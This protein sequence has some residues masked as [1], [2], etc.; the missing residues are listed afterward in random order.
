MVYAPGRH[1]PNPF[2]TLLQTSNPAQFYATYPFWVDPTTDDR[3][4][5][6]YT[7]KP[8][9]VLTTLSQSFFRTRTPDVTNIGLFLLVN[10][11][12]ITIGLTLAAIYLPLWVLSRRQS[13]ERWGTPIGYFF[14]LGLGFMFLEIALL[15]RFTLLL[16][17][18]VYS[19]AVT[20]A[21]LLVFGGCGSLLSNR[22]A[23]DL[24]ARRLEWVF[25]GIGLL[26]LL[27]AWILPHLFA[28]A[29]PY[30]LPVRMALCAFLLLPIGLLLGMPFPIGI[31]RLERGQHSLI[32]WAWASNGGASVL[33][34]SLAM[35][36]ALHVGFTVVLIVGVFC[37]LLA[38]FLFHHWVA[39]H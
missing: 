8:S 31:R 26:G 12:M 10:S 32:P 9:Q 36:V 24:Q 5:F 30:M 18:P 2:T 28:Y 15:Q 21:A 34:A 11:V 3:P 1:L 37:Y 20:L 6:F 19:L 17:Y 22:F 29:I 13:R 7:L 25:I 38:W 14:C 16:S 23:A 39:S 27:Y 33:G 4:F 35:L